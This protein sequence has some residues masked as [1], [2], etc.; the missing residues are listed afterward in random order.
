MT[1]YQLVVEPAINEWLIAN[2]KQRTLDRIERKT[3]DAPTIWPSDMGGCHRKTALR[4]TGHTST[5][6]PSYDGLRYMRTG[7]AIEDETAAAMVHYYGRENV[8]LQ[9]ALKYKHWSGKPDFVLYHDNPDKTPVI[10]EHKATGE[11]SFHNEGTIPRWKHIGQLALYG[12]LYKKIYN[13]TPELLLYYRGWGDYAEIRLTVVGETIEL[14][15]VS[16]NKPI[17]KVINYDVHKE[18]KII[19]RVYENAI[20]GK[21]MPDRLDKKSDGCSWMGRPSCDFYYHCYPEEDQYLN[22]IPEGE[23]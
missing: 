12:Y 15:G 20:T 10:I 6:P 5:L 18:I 4:V 16:N 23:G 13:V 17:I 19:E 8:T 7:E 22:N 1:S 2:E 3:N 11:K 21:S 9:L 14:Y